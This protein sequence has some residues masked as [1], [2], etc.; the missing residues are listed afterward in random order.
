MKRIAIFTI[1]PL[2]LFG[3]DEPVSTISQSNNVE[4]VS[5]GNCS[6]TNI[7]KTNCSLR[8]EATGV[9]VVPCSGACSTAQAKVMAR[10]AAIVDGYKAL[11]EKLYGIKINGRDTIKNMI[12]QNSNVRGYVQGLIRGAR[13]EE[14]EY[15]DGVYSVVMS[16]KL[17]IKEWNNFIKNG[18]VR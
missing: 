17:N 8:V 9:G 6:I 10:R 13:I 5:S 7:S 12:L 1:L 3:M 18:F 15:K 14:E 4:A 16:V 11:S 2:F